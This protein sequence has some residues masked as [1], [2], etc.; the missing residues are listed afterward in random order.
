MYSQKA[1]AHRGPGA[2]P[3]EAPNTQPA[4]AHNKPT[5]NAACCPQAFRHSPHRRQTR[6]QRH[7]R[8][9][10]RGPKRAHRGFSALPTEAP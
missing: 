1:P 7:P 3:T 2:L 6:P 4:E 10:H 8:G 5:G 9:A